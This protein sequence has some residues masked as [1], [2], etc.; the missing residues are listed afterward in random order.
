MNEAAIVNRVELRDFKSI[1]RC[2]VYLGP[3]TV[4]VGPNGAGK[5]NFVDALHFASQSLVKPLGETI[6]ER[7]GIAEVV[8]RSPH[9]RTSFSIT[10]DFSLP[11]GIGHGQYGF[12]IKRT[13][14]GGF[15][16]AREFCEVLYPDSERHVSRF[17]VN[18]GRLD[19]VGVPELLP[20]P[21]SDRLLL[22]SASNSDVF[23]PVYDALSAMRFYR[24]APD[25]FRAPQPVE[26]DP[27]LHTHDG[28]NLASVLN[29]MEREANPAF[30]RL[31]RYMQSIVPELDRVN[32]LT[33]P[34]ANLMLVGF[35]HQFGDR[36]SPI[37][38]T[39]RNMS[40]GTLRALA[41]LTALL[42]VNPDQRRPL[43]GGKYPPTFIAIEEPETT[44]HPAAAGVLWDALTDGSDRT[45]LMV[46]TQSSD[47]LDRDDVPTDSILAV[48]MVAGKT[49]IGPITENSRRLLQE[50]LA[51]PGELLRQRR[52]SSKEPLTYPQMPVRFDA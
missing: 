27:Y 44:L 29:L 4:L 32:V 48:D 23:Y 36:Q 34:E 12:E 11:D 24:F 42:Q 49:E 38:F 3:L 9:P 20:R 43:G 30:E 6:H 25:V 7:G 1:S 18:E 51:T 46:T 39:G 37:Q 41:I 19:S 35:T 26:N 33:F 52:L 17:E 47:L 14:T 31:Q 8:R 10:C 15:A 22:T 40:D 13:S 21:S 2:D 16:V 45:Q 50:R 28:H 5:S